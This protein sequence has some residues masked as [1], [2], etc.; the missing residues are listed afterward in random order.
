MVDEMCFNESK[1]GSTVEY[2]PFYSRLDLAAT[3]NHLKI[4]H[5][6]KSVAVKL[7]SC[8]ILM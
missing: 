8:W 6:W 2:F 4:V 3:S 1:F 7:H 5:V